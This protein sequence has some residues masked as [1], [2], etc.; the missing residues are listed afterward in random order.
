M[1]IKTINLKILGIGLFIGCL[2][3]SCN[4]NK[5]AH[6]SEGIA[7]YKVLSLTPQN[8][9]LYSEFPAQIEG[10]EN[11]EIRPKIE[12]FIEKV[13]VDEGEYVEKGRLLFVL[14][15]PQYAQEVRNTQAAISSAE[16]EV[17]S[18]QLE[19]EKARPLVE[20]GI[21]S[22]FQ[23]TSAEN[24]LKAK[25]AALEQA[26]TSLANAKT[27]YS[28]TQ[29][30]APVSGYIGTLPYKLGS[31]VSSSTADPLTTVSNIKKVYAYFSIN[32]KIHLEIVRKNQD[33]STKER[34][35]NPIEVH[36]L[37]PDYT[38]YDQKGKIQTISG[39]VDEETGS[40][41]VRAI[42]DNPENLL[43]TGNSATIRIP[44]TIENA[45]QIPQSATYEIQGNVYAYVVD[46]LSQAQ[47]TKITVTPSTSGQANIVTDGLKANDQVII[48]GVNTLSNGM[49]IQPV[50]VNA[51]EVEALRVSTI[52]DN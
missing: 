46:S 29:I 50:Q 36:L 16:A 7:E 10:I 18:A 12:G 47:S 9:D 17:S 45:L 40:F 20:R 5:D 30:S 24:T 28:Y 21:I 34:M 44:N 13:L 32:E 39:Q 15:A 41:N 42:F 19:V 33:I 22:S 25:K 38:M 52:S 51:S 2:S 49:K 27:N 48:E 1:K 6:L 3:I 8:V 4:G 43:R 11:I 31:L 37:L 23:L 14:N 26:Q 35:E